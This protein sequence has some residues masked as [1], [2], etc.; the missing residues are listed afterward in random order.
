MSRAALLNPENAFRE[1]SKVDFDS[2]L[3]QA[4]TFS[5][6]SLRALTTLAVIEPC[7]ALAPKTKKS[8]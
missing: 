7:L 2:S 5:D 3:S 4:A 1:V 6:K 8:K